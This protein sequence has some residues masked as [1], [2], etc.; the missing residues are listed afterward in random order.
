M[1]P[2]RFRLVC[3][4]GGVFLCGAVQAAPITFNFNFASP[5]SSA[6][7]IGYI[8]FDDALL[9]NPGYNDFELPDPAVLALSVTVSG[10]TAGNGTFSLSNF[11]YVI[12]DTN[13]ASLD[14]SRQLVGQPTPGDPWGMPSEGGGGTPTVSARDGGEGDAGDFNLLACQ[15]PSGAGVPSGEY[16]FALLPD[17]GSEDDIMEL[18]SML[19]DGAAAS[20]SAP[21]PTLSWH[22]LLLLAGLMGLFGMW[23]VRRNRQI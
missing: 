1:S 14:F 23:T 15:G 21:I 8:T 13:G 17:S 3:L 4:M 16:P 18:V 11:C 22:A 10:A 6:Q 19:R 12:F 20:S 9:L 5:N 2:F 7:A